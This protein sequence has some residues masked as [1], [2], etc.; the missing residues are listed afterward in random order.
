MEIIGRIVENCEKDKTAQVA[1]VRSTACGHSCASCGAC[2]GREHQ[3]IA[4]NPDNYE[5]GRVVYVKVDDKAPLMMAFVVYMLPILAVIIFC[6]IIG[7]IWGKSYVWIGFVAGI[8]PWIVLLL[9]MNKR[10]AKKK[11]TDGVITGAF[12]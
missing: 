5:T 12:D 10:A 11:K 2:T 1:I 8:V 3:I 4:S 6:M 9:T 7:L